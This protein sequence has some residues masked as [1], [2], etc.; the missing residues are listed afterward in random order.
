[1]FFK[2]VKVQN[3]F[4]EGVGESIYSLYSFKIL[5][6][7]ESP[8]NT[9][10]LNMCVSN[11]FNTAPDGETVRNQAS[12]AAHL[13]ALASIPWLSH[14]REEHLQGTVTQIHGS[15]PRTQPVS[16]TSYSSL[17]RYCVPSLRH[18]ACWSLN[19]E[20]PVAFEMVV[21]MNIIHCITASGNQGFWTTFHVKHTV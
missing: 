5:M 8:H 2:N 16:L 11:C 7:M 17:P 12:P 1:M 9:W 13:G 20:H 4:C 21:K 14:R 6:S 15:A 10:K 18:K 19:S 3:V